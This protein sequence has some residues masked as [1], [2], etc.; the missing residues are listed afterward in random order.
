MYLKEYIISLE[1]NHRFEIETK[2]TAIYCKNMAHIALPFLHLDKQM[3]FM[4]VSV[5]FQPL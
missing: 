1:R 5:L 3:F 4:T 2:R